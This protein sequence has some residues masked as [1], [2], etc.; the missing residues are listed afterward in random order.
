[1]T[2][3]TI[4]RETSG[5]SVSRIGVVDGVRTPFAK[6]GA[7]LSEFS[8]LD[9]AALAVRGLA[10]RTGVGGDDVDTLVLGSA[11]NYPSIAYLAREVGIRLGWHNTDAYSAESACATSVRTTVNAAQDL[12]LGGRQVAIAGGAESLSHQPI[13]V[14]SPLHSVILHGGPSNESSLASAMQ[15]T[16]GDLFPPRPGIAEP[17][18]G[19]SLGEHAE[20]IV[21]DWRIT[22]EDSD[23]FAVASHHKAAKAMNQ[24]YLS[25][26]IVEVV[27]EAGVVKQDQLVR[28]DTSIDKVSGLRPVFDPDNGTVTAAN[29][30]P[31]TDGA[32]ALLLMTEEEIRR[33]RIQPK[34][35]IRSWAL[36]A[37]DPRVGVLLGPAFALPEAL[38]RAGLTADE[39]DLIDLHEAFAGQVLAN[40]AALRSPE[41]AM[42]HRRQGFEPIDFPESKI[43]VLGGSIAIGHPFGATGARLVM[44]LADEMLRQG[45]RYGALAVCAGGSRGAAMVLEAAA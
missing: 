21:R 15:L 43:N 36:T 17:Y 35:W 42:A 2:R 14:S 11:L 32:S 20:E 16:I 31:L 9:L 12:L 22:R 27:T 37:H 23:A 10:E 8:A 34:A 5:V 18:S 13:E 28:P 1:M 3:R 40:L 33:R 6:A 30:S 24:G 39:V 38:A 19:K 4:V 25:S 26:S 7:Q 44:Q 45:V 29:A 41:Q